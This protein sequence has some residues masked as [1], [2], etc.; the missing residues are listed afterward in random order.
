MARRCFA[1]PLAVGGGE[2]GG[3]GEARGD[4][5]LDDRQVGLAQEL[6]GFFLQ[7]QVAMERP[8]APRTSK[9]HLT[10]TGSSSTLGTY[11]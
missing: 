2:V 5:D 6:A 9:D 4:R 7:A 3:A 11:F 1:E 8:R 10:R